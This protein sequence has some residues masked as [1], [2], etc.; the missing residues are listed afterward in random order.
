MSLPNL[1]EKLNI[2]ILVPCYK[3]PEYTK[4]CIKALKEAQEYDARTQF[5]LVDDGSK[6]GTEEILRNSDLPAM[7][8]LRKENLGLR[9][10]LID[11]IKVAKEYNFDMLGVIGN[12]C[13][14]PKDWLNDLLDVF[15]KTNVDVLSPNYLP[16]NPALNHGQEDTTGLVYRPSK[17]VGGLWFMAT[18]LMDGITFEDY[19]VGGIYAAFNILHQVLIEKDPIV[20]WTDKVTMQD[21]GH[22]SGKHPLN[23]KS[24]EHSDYY[25]EVG[26]GI[27]W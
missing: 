22:W 24:K 27:A 23:I 8:V 25:Q 3:R 7:Y 26:R 11:F 9:R 18:K 19:N 20:G 14:V 1:R 16:S 12:D 5:L 6:D 15:E 2:L 10:V 13:L 21:L 4:Q 17:I